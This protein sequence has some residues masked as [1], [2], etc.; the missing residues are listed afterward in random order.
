[1]RYWSSEVDQVPAAGRDRRV[2]NR[3][4]DSFFS[5]HIE[6]VRR[7]EANPCDLDFAEGCLD[8]EASNGRLEALVIAVDATRED[9]GKVKVDQTDADHPASADRLREARGNRVLGRFTFCGLAGY[10]CRRCRRG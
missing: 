1:M 4:I 7:S 3:E 6:A 2:A 10:G 8:E 5:D 9:E